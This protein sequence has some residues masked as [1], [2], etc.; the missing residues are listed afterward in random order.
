MRF[1]NA[2]FCGDCLTWMKNFPDNLV[3]LI[4]L[5][6]PF[7]S[8]RH[9]EVIFDDG[10]EIRSFEDRW[11]GGIWHYVEWMRERVFE[12]HRILKDDG[13]LFLHC[14]HHA[15]HYLKTMLD[16][17]FGRG[18]FINEIIWCYS[19]GGRPTTAFG[20]KHDTIFWYA[21]GEDWTF[22]RED[23]HV[24]VPRKSGSHMKVET[25]PQGRQWQVKTDRKSG[26]KYYYPADKVAEDYWTD[27][28]QLNR[29]AEERVSYPTQK[30]RALLKRIISA[31]SN[32]SDLV[33]DPF[34]GCGTTL[35]AA[36]TLGRKWIG[37]DVSPTACK[38][39]KR[40]VEHIGAEN[41]NTENL[42]M[43]VE[44]LKDLEPYEFQNYIIGAMS[45][46]TSEKKVKDMGIDGYTFMERNPIQVK[47]KES[48]GRPEID[49]FETALK[50]YYAGRMRAA[51][52]RG[53]EFI[54]R[55][56][57]IA[58]SY[59]GG[60]EGAYE[61]IARAKREDGIEI[62]PMTVQEIMKDFAN[63]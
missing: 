34:C 51:K 35:T 9:Y 21:K 44:E 62:I 55:G 50:R 54:M 1:E 17:V 8:N 20:R 27:I 10:A 24:R 11:K 45:G 53:E 13:T 31:A 61:E 33:L 15:G 29:D 47:Q 3:D 7:F 6:P 28:E 22:N 52:E 48:V 42:P 46:T 60:N 4:Y 38:I 18:H 40:E 16:D 2:I 37:I 14:D 59:T 36:Q 19:L 25:D 32:E 43:S 26:K 41:V 23:P 30:P 63:D 5:D 49:E 58:F 57:Y 12:M 39:M 56:V